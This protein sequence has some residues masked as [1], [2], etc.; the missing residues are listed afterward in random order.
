MENPTESEAAGV[1]MGGGEMGSLMRS[2]AWASTPL[3]PV[4]TWP[5]NLRTL[6][7]LMLGSTNHMHVL[8]GPQLTLLYNDSY[9]STLGIKHPNALG[10]SGADVWAEAWGTLGPMVEHTMSAGKSSGTKDLQLFVQRGT[11]PGECLEECYF[12]FCYSPIRSDLGQVEGVFCTC[13]ETTQQVIGR[14]RLRTLRSLDGITTPIKTVFEACRIAVDTLADNPHDVPF[15]L[16]YLLEDDLARLAGATGIEPDTKASPLIIDLTELKADRD[17]YSTRGWEFAQVRSRQQKITLENLSERFD[18]ALTDVWGHALSKAVVR[19]LVQPASAQMLGFL[20]MGVSPTQPLDDDYQGFFD[21]VVAHVE[22]ALVNAKVHSSERD[23]LASLVRSDRA[24]R[25]SQNQL[26]LALKAGRIGAW[27]LN[28]KTLE[29]TTS[30]Q[31]KTNYGLA[32]DADFTHQVLIN[33]IHPDDKAWV[34]AALEQAIASDRPYDVEYRILWDDGS[35]HW[36]VSRA[37]LVASETG[38]PERLVGISINITERKRAEEAIRESEQRFRHIVESSMF[39]T[40]FAD[41][42]GG[43]RYANAYFKD[44]LGYSSDELAAGQ[45]RWDQLTPPE[46]AAFDSNAIAQLNDKGVCTPYEKVFRHKD[47]RPI[48]ILMTAALLQAP[49]SGAPQLKQEAIGVFLDLTDIKQ[50]TAER[51]RFFQ[52]SPDLFCIANAQGYFTYISSACKRILGFTAGEMTAEPYLSFIHPDDAEDTAIIAQRVA[53]GHHLINFENRYRH[54]DGSYRWILWNVTTTPSAELF[55]CIGHDITGRKQKE[56]ERED[57]LQREQAAREAAE[58]ANRI[59]DEFLAVVSHELRSPLNPILGWSQLLKRGQLSP[60]KTAQALEIIERNAKLQVQL[61]GDLLDISRILRGKL[62]LEKKPTDLDAVIT[63]SIETVRT[64]AEAK[65]I[66]VKTITTP[67]TVIGDYGRLQQIVWNLLSNAIKFTPAGGQVTITATCQEN[68]AQIEVT[69][70]GKGIGP[71]FLPFVFEHFQQEDYSTTRKFGGLGLGLAIARQLVELH[72]GAIA[73]DSPGENQGATFTVHIP[74]AA[75]RTVSFLTPP[76]AIAPNLQGIQIL[77]VDDDPDSQ[78]ITAF[79]LEQAGATITAVSSGAAALQAL[80]Q[81]SP[82]LLISDIGMPDMDGYTLIREIR[83]RAGLQGKETIAVAL[84]AYAGELDQQQALAAGFQRH[85]T[86]PIDPDA[87]V[88]I[89]SELLSAGTSA[90]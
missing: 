63:A 26:N 12:T 4:E 51:D 46:F 52:L 70:T 32:S 65:S 37:Y 49:D 21:L 5:Q 11:G 44:L 27:Q 85:L 15:A 16:L 9:R 31:G 76:T 28:L 72:E 47:G 8:W 71:E 1:F 17:S 20:V 23:R 59:K 39:G 43:I 80:S 24:L 83:K 60:E 50:V 3:G 58:Q 53:E 14:R 13:S 87:L 79:A 81:S 10:K 33:R 40:V 56:A 61:I 86:K 82:E 78:E 19:P 2:H 84:T 48:P 77:I 62:S 67:C 69:D 18:V 42:E 55:Y 7:S 30:E 57:L 89:I 75:S 74:T 35:V 25:E 88:A 22:T 54:K 34:Q 64:A 6:V 73:V 66:Q 29:L 36:V 45:V 41:L 38:E 90:Q 68:H